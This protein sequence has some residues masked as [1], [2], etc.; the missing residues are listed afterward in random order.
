MKCTKFTSDYTQFLRR[1]VSRLIV[2]ASIMLL[3]AGTAAAFVIDIHQKDLAGIGNLATADSIIATPGTLIAS[4]SAKIIDFD[5]LGDSTQGLFSINNPWPGGAVSSFAAHVTGAFSLGADGIF[6]LGL[7]HDDG[8]RLMI[9]GV[10]WASADGVVDNR[11]SEAT[12][13]LSAGVHKVDIVYFENFGGAS[14]EFYSGNAGSGGLVI[15]EPTILALLA[16]G[17]AGMGFSRRRPVL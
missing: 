13:F 12:G 15:P 5:D 1:L 2:V 6:T 7:N 9:D 14:L 3:S 17:L 8:A 4:R 16:L 10:T 11:N